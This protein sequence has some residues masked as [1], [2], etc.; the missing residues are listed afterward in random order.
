MRLAIIVSHPIQYYSPWF[1]H[2]AEHMRQE[3]EG[4]RREARGQRPEDGDPDSLHA[5]ELARRV[6]KRPTDTSNLQQNALRVFYLWDFGVTEK[7]DKGFGKV[8]KWDVDLLEGY[9]HELVPNVSAR[10][11]TDWF[12]GL[13][14]PGLSQRVKA[15]APDAVLQ[16]GYNYKSLVNFDLRWN[17]KRAPL[18]FRGDSHLLAEDGERGK[19]QEAMGTRLKR[20]MRE[21]GLRLL[22]RRF[23]C[24]LAVGKAN[25]DYFRAHGVPESKIVRCPHVVDNEFFRREPED[26]RGL[27]DEET[28]GL[29]DWESRGLRA[30][31][32]IPEDELVFLFAGKLEEKKQPG[33]L[34]EAFLAADLPKATLLFVGSG[35]LE[36]ALKEKASHSRVFETAEGKLTRMK[37]RISPLGGADRTGQECSSPE[38]PGFRGES[39]EGEIAEQES[40]SRAERDRQLGELS[41]AVKLR[42]LNTDGVRAAAPTGLRG[43]CSAPSD[44]GARKGPSQKTEDCKLTSDDCEHRV[45]FLP[46]QNQSRMPLVYRLGDALVLPSG[47]WETWGLAVN[48]AQACGRPSLVSDCVGCARDIIREGENGMIFR[49][50]DWGDCVSVMGQM[51][52]A[53]S[54]ETKRPK[55]EESKGLGSEKTKR[56]PSLR[57]GLPCNQLIRDEEPSVA[58]RR[59]AIRAGAWEFDTARGADALLRGIR[60][61]A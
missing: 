42:G 3:V 19:G 43:E 7:T 9:D 59:E 52:D 46:F 11:G 10:P 14:N 16:F 22:F 2:I 40:H 55:D 53:W 50:D 6:A 37:G 29:K 47:Y 27:K 26:T 8:V 60:Q 12:G 5:A 21:I 61:T 32:G 44:L 49:T 48:E 20:W 51:V 1:R 25:A 33:Q 38:T 34:L 17:T 41:E 58:S 23:A 36:S 24:F 18:L 31:L 13:D 54:E 56:Q 45:L 35:E 30:E 39:S 15:F 57:D 28:K 4:T